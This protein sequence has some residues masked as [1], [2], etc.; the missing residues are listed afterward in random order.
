MTNDPK[1]ETKKPA[2]RPVQGNSSDHQTPNPRPP[3]P[4]KADG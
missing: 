4:K 3:E 1:N 2:E